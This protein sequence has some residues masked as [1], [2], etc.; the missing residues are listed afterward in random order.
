MVRKVLY[1]DRSGVLLI[2]Y[3][4]DVNTPKR[5]T[6]AMSTLRPSRRVTKKNRRY[7]MASV[8]APQGFPVSVQ[9]CGLEGTGSGDPAC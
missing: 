5:H 4:A 2:R 9:S 7:C 8:D 3:S 1:G 6:E